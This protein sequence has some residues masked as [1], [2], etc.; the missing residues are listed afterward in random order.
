[1]HKYQVGLH[2]AELL[3]LVPNI[4]TVF[5][6]QEALFTISDASK[7]TKLAIMVFQV[8]ELKYVS[9]A[10]LLV[11]LEEWFPNDSTVRVEVSKAAGETAL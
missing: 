9:R 2:T 5:V 8:L 4:T 11:K 1:M 10:K 6:E 7:S 3:E